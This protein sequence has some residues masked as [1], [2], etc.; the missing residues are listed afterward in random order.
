MVTYIYQAGSAGA[1]MSNFWSLH[2]PF[3][4]NNNNNNNNNHVSIMKQKIIIIIMKEIIN[5]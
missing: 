3:Y 2:V 1:M 4:T 5:N